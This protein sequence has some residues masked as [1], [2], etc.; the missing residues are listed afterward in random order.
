MCGQIT[1]VFAFFC[2]QVIR[3]RRTCTIETYLLPKDLLVGKQSQPIFLKQRTGFLSETF[4]TELVE[5]SKHDEI[6]EYKTILLWKKNFKV[7]TEMTVVSQRLTTCSDVFIVV[8]FWVR[9][10]E[11]RVVLYLRV[12]FACYICLLY[13]HVIFAW[14]IFVLYFACIWV[15]YLSV[16]S[17]CYIRVFPCV[18]YDLYLT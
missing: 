1:I 14:Y 3:L 15:S 18:V 2:P 9:D 16:I 5:A 7:K 17:E 8:I 10:W 6:S 11:L 12:I 4:V 13:F